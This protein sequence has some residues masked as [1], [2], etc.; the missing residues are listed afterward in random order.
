[1]NVF[2]IIFYYTNQHMLNSCSQINIMWRSLDFCSLDDDDGS[3]THNV[4]RDTLRKTDKIHPCS[5]S[6]LSS[7]PEEEDCVGEKPLMII[8]SLSLHSVPS[9]PKNTTEPAEYVN[10]K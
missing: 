1:M 9:S 10:Y 6:S 2:K 5:A 4:W 3:S 7:G 8:N